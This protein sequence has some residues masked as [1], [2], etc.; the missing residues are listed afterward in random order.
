M[1]KF[2]RRS[3]LAATAGAAAC[4]GATTTVAHAGEAPTP[5]PQVPLGK[6]GITMSRVGQGTGMHGGNR[7]SDHS[8]MGFEKLVSLLK[9]D[10]ERGITFFDLAD[11][12]GTHLYC[13]EAL[14]TLPRKE[15]TLLTKLWW[16]YD[17]PTVPVAE[18]YRKR[19]A[20]S[21]LQRFCHEL[22]TDY[23]DIVLLHCASKR[24]WVDELVPYMD[25]LDEAKKKG[26]VRAVGVSC[27][28]L[29][30]MQAA[31]ECPWV[32]VL[33][34]RINHKGVKMDG[35]TEEVTEVLRRTKENG[36]AVIGMKIYGEGQLAEERDECIRFAQ[37]LGLID[38]M[39][40]GALTPAEMDETLR[41]IAKYPAAKVG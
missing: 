40:V 39:T 18:S 5:P 16:R 30:A 9:H 1:H 3:F 35:T 31:A 15:L 23:I 4:A 2:N 29:G 7:Q 13:R 20:E 17:G 26:Q 10:F 37:G 11:L 33:L 14:R 41:L 12:Y 38:A 25:A 27:H 24:E 34:A 19:V 6:T 21:T 32:D 28:D 22:A 36:K 8:R